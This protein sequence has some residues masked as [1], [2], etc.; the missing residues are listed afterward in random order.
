M[1]SCILRRP[2]NLAEERNKFLR[3]LDKVADVPPEER[4]GLES[5][6]DSAS[7]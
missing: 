4:D 5:A 6:G 2:W 7:H 1:S 3:A